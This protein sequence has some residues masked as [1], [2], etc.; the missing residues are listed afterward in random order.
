MADWT[1][2][3]A[4]WFCY[5]RFRSAAE[6]GVDAPRAVPPRPHPHR[7][8]WLL[9]GGGAGRGA[10]CVDPRGSPAERLGRPAHPGDR[11]HSDWGR[12]RRAGV[13]DA[14]RRHEG[15][16]GHSRMGVAE[17]RAQHPRGALRRLRRSP[18]R[19]ALRG[20]SASNRRPVRARRCVGLGGGA[21]RLL[22][23]R[24]AGSADRPAVGD[25]RGLCCGHDHPAMPGL[26]GG[27]CRCT[28]RSSTR[29]PSCWESLRC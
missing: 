3:K 6:G 10:G 18:A 20:L 25:H 23:G 4:R 22:P 26:R 7:V 13:R 2:P 12:D 19:Q 9:R 21:D 29:S 17:R 5:R 1:R 27:G 16:G 24:G 8:A 14:R 15:R 11:G 28:R